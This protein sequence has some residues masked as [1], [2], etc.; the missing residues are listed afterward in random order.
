MPESET[1]EEARRTLF[2]VGP[3]LFGPD[4][5][6]DIAD[7]AGELYVLPGS[8]GGSSDQSRRERDVGNGCESFS[9]E[10]GTLG[11]DKVVMMKRGGCLFAQKVT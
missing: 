11:K 8:G 9:E 7:L 2:T 1:S 5:G 10:Q 6:T 3:A 4:L